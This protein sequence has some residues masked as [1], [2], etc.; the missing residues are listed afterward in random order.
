MY[1]GP[2]TSSSSP[3][4]LN[5]SLSVTRSIASL[6]SES[7]TMRSKIR[8]CASR[9]KSPESMTSAAR[10]NASL[11]SRMAPRTERSASRL[12]GSV[13]SEIVVSGIAG[14]TQVTTDNSQVTS[15]NLQS[16]VATCEL[17]LTFSAFGNHP[18]LD[19]RDDLAAQPERHVVLA[20]L[21]DRFGELQLASIDL[22]APGQQRRRDVGG[23]HRSEQHV[24]FADTARNLDL[25][26]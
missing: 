26:V 5:S 18:N 1:A 23:R 4:R 10:L 9:K 2:P 14:R 24:G 17:L 19:V 21:L 11:W 7:F 3:E 15:R 12:C 20:Q 25:E 16:S 22:I 6:R 8:R 13:R